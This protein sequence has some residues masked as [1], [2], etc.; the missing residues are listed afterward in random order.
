MSIFAVDSY[1]KKSD[2]SW[3]NTAAT[4]VVTDGFLG[5][6]F[7]IELTKTMSVAESTG[8]GSI[9]GMSGLVIGKGVTQNMIARYSEHS[10]DQYPVITVSLGDYG[11]Y[12]V[13]VK[14]VD[15]SDATQIEMF[16]LCSYLDDKNITC[17]GSTGSYNRLKSYIQSAIDM[18]ELPDINSHVNAKK[19]INWLKGFEYSMKKDIT[20]QYSYMERSEQTKLRSYFEKQCKDLEI[21]KLLERARG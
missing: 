1:E 20:D 9:L 16:A 19:K 5:S 13:A 21:R 7:N 4:K 10:T 6:S 18:D 15:P 12:D 3:Y 2:R 17:P 14:D 11:S 8:Q